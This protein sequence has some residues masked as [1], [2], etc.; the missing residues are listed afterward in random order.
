[1]RS[2]DDISNRIFDLN[3]RWEQMVNQRDKDVKIIKD[4][5]RRIEELR[6]L[7]FSLEKVI[8]GL[9]IRHNKEKEAL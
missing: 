1:M 5:E 6:Q 3:I 9:K 4:H 2:H 7:N 8:E